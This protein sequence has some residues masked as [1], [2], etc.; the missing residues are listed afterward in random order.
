MLTPPKLL[1]NTEEL[2]RSVISLPCFPWMSDEDIDLVV[3]AIN[4]WE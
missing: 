3:S 1:K 2:S 4:A